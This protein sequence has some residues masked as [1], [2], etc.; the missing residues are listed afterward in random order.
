MS[1]EVSILI[2]VYNTEKYLKRCL[3]SV[4]SQ[5]LKNIEIIVVND[6]SNDNSQDIIEEYATKDSR[7]KYYIQKNSGLGATRNKGIE[8]AQGEYIAFLDSDDWVEAN[9]YEK[10]YKKAI[11]ED[12]DLVIC[13][14]LI[15]FYNKSIRYKNKYYNND[16]DR[17]MNDVIL[18]NVS[19]FSWNKLYKKSI[20]DDYKMRFPVR[21]ELENVEDQYF[22]IRYLYLSKSISFENSCLIHYTI[23]SSS[24]VNSYQRNILEDGVLLYKSNY[25][26]FKLHNASE[27]I[28]DLLNLGLL[29]HI[30]HTI[31]N[32]MKSCN[33]YK[34]NDKI[35]NLAKIIN[36][37]IC[38]KSLV[39]FHENKNILDLNNDEKLYLNLLYS[40][41]IYILYFIAKL[42]SRISELRVK[43]Y[44]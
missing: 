13:N 15:D 37:D 33:K 31:R 25:N 8:L 35:K 9:C 18:R 28:Y 1:I 12:S 4:I 2:P 32:E 34:F 44:K 36:D 38:Y 23:R 16:K 3:D 27:N 22:T 39:Y 41:K 10:L 21:G 26:F 24:I 6:G 30:I 20:I 40:N 42:R 43:C 5:T 17:Y 29:K 11:K 7:I 14:Y 19:G